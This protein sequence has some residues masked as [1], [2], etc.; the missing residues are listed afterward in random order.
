MTIWLY[1]GTPGSGKSYHA[2]YDIYNRLQRKGKRQQYRRMVMTNFFV[3]IKSDFCLE[4]AQEQIT[5]SFFY[6][7]AMEHHVVGIE[8]QTL[9][10][11]DEAGTIFN[12]RDWGTNSAKRMEWI[13]FFS[14]HRHYGFNFILIAQMDRMIDRQIRGLIEYEIAHSKINNFFRIIPFTAFL[15]VERWYGQRLKI[16]HSVIPYRKKI[17]NLYNSYAIF[18]HAKTLASLAPA[19]QERQREDTRNGAEGPAS[20]CAAGVDSS[21]I[22]RS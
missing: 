17:A 13:K 22:L 16:T 7:Y 1:S 10:V 15:A 19:G 21:T 14:M 18:S 20:C 4:L 9:V 11:L 12:S 3:N 6:D 5:P 8:G 2:V